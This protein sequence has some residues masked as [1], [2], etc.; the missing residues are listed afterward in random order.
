VKN[1][2]LKFRHG[3][4]ARQIAR[5]HEALGMT[6]KSLH[7]AMAVWDER[8]Q[9]VLKCA[10]QDALH[11]MA[12]RIRALM[13]GLEEPFVQAA[14]MDTPFASADNPAAWN[15]WLDKRESSDGAP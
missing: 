1:L 8:H 4:D 12:E 3:V 14:G 5:V 13:Y 6:V 2:H 15:E 7:Q 11:R 9:S 10:S